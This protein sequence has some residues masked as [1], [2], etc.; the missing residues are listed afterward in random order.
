V[1]RISSMI[2]ALR[3]AAIPVKRVVENC[4]QPG[5]WL[6][7][8]RNILLPIYFYSCVK[9]AFHSH[10]ADLRFGIAGQSHTYSVAVEDDRIG[11]D[12]KARRLA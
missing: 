2:A 9:I 4:G 6:L 10:L 3:F 5:L 11:W 8:P 12:A 7:L 1:I